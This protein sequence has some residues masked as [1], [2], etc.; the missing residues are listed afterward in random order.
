MNRRELSGCPG[1]CRGVRG[2]YGLYLFPQAVLAYLFGIALQIIAQGGKH[3]Q[4]KLPWNLTG[5]QCTMIM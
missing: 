2:R 5:A 1:A 4:A 3:M